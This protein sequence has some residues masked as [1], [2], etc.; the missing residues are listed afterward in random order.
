MS[1][2]NSFNA[3]LVLTK[4]SGTTMTL[5]IPKMYDF[6]VKIQK[7]YRIVDM[8]QMLLVNYCTEGSSCSELVIK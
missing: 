4:T 2:V 6:I 1:V 8:M 5:S 3:S 7:F